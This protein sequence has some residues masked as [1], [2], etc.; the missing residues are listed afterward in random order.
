[1]LILLLLYVGTSY[2]ILYLVRLEFRGSRFAIAALVFIPGFWAEWELLLL[3]SVVGPFER[4]DALYW[5]IEEN[6]VYTI[7]EICTFTTPLL[8]V[9]WFIKRKPQVSLRRKGE[10][11]RIPV[12]W[13]PYCAIVCL[14]LAVSSYFEDYVTLESAVIANDIELT[15]RRLEF[16]LLLRGPNDGGIGRPYSSS[17]LRTYPLLPIAVWHNNRE[18]V[19]L[20]LAH[21]AD[22][23]PDDWNSWVED[24][25]KWTFGRGAIPRST[26]AYAV[27][28]NN[29]PM[30]DYLLEKG[31][32]PS[33]GI[34]P[35]VYI[36]NGELLAYLLDKGGDPTEGVRSAIFRRNGDML[37]YLLHR[38]ADRTIT[39][40]TAIKFN[41]PRAV[42]YLLAYD[43]DPDAVR[44]AL[45]NKGGDVDFDILESWCQRGCDLSEVGL[46]G[47]YW[48]PTWR[49]NELPPQE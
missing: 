42:A 9:W 12:I 1:M 45:R 40:K 15:R 5:L 37:E 30:L 16:N 48:E 2:L 21:G 41:S 19:D 14:L 18:M 46:E 24:I 44:V 29:R 22:L 4:R 43:A 8:I 25:D 11:A 47:I 33:Q 35:A 49:H 17:G 23:N 36:E 31:A 3:H 28:K 32:N 26:L 20:L 34:D 39:L 38:G 10:N 13:L 6:S 27:L 7:V